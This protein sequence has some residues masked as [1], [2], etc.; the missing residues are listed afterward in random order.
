MPQFGSVM[1]MF[2]KL[3][4]ARPIIAYVYK[5]ILLAISSVV[6]VQTALANPV[7]Y[8]WTGLYFGANAGYGAG[9]ANDKMLLQDDWMNDGSFDYLYLNPLGTNQ[10]KSKG[11]IGGLQFGF[12]YQMQHWVVGLE[13]DRNALQMKPTFY[14]EAYNP[15][16]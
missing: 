13:V 16:C 11:F 5:P 8:D 1:T 7:P 6:L 2:N 4:Y 14:G 10:L 12:N 9:H 3:T 15:H